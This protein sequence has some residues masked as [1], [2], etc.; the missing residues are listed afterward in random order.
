MKINSARI[1]AGKLLLKGRGE[2]FYLPDGV[3]RRDDGHSVTVHGHQIVDA[4][5]PLDPGTASQGDWENRLEDLA[6]QL[7]SMAHDAQLANIDLQN[8][9]QTQQQTL[10]TIA[11]VQK[12]LHDTA[13]A[14][15]R[16]IG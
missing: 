12:M 5:T 10:Q 15:V 8:A 16:K 14:I 9:L 13:M 4:L 6:E 2:E 7:S 1:E 11:N 3:Y